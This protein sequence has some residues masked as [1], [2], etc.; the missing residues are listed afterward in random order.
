[1]LASERLPP[2]S[3]N[4]MLNPAK[5][6][7]VSLEEFTRLNNETEDLS[8]S[9]PPVLKT[10][11]AS[12]T[13]TSMASTDSLRR[14]TSTGVGTFLTSGNRGREKILEIQALIA[15]DKQK[16]AERQ[17][18]HTLEQKQELELSISRTRMGVAPS[19]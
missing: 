11:S 14:T 3:K 5:T 9:A 15:K 19:K 1:M 7:L 8:S 4:Q 6:G 16:K 13:A 10:S 12:M 17:L 2:K 18:K